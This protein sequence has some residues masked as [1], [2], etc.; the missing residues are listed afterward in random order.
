MRTNSKLTPRQAAQRLGVRLDSI[1]SLLWAGKLAAT[2]HE[3]RWRIDAP[4]VER[5]LI[6]RRGL[7]NE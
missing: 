5:R 3:G 6:A 1:Y 4:S 2:K 7:T